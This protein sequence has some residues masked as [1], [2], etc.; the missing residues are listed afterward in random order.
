M[1]EKTMFETV[2]RAVRGW[3]DVQEGFEKKRDAEG[4]LWAT[5]DTELVYV[6]HDKDGD[7]VEQII[8]GLEQGLEGVRI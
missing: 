6:F 1:E 3:V 7:P 4:S 5:L 8:E 2:I